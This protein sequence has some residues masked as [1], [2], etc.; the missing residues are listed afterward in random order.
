ML[1]YEALIESAKQMGMPYT[2][3]RGILREYLQVLILKEIYQNE[4]GKNLFFTGGTYLRIVHKLKRFSEDIDFNTKILRK[5][6]FEDLLMKI[7]NGLAKN[8]IISNLEFNH[9]NKILSADIIFP[10]IEKNYNVVSKYSKKKGITIKVETNVPVWKI[11]KETQ[12][13]SGFGEFFPCVCTER[14]ALF[15]DKIDAVSKKKRGRHIYDLMFMLSNKF[16]INKNVLKTYN[17]KDN[18]LDYIVKSINN[19]SQLELKNMAESLRPFLFEEK[20]ADMVA[21]AREIVPL[22]AE[23]YKSTKITL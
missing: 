17:I 10:E 19:F 1:T 21:N 7:K 9:W 8:G 5:K 18:P 20:E 22:L 11:E 13:V 2:K 16:P 23:Q 15:A 14:A 6:Q 3:V 12:V 4:N